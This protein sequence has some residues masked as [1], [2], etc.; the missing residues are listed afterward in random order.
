VA[1]VGLTKARR[2]LVVEDSPDIRE[3]WVLWFTLAGFTVTVAA[4]GR[5]ALEQVRRERPDVVLMDLSMPVM[6]GIEASGGF[7]A[8]RPQLICRFL[9]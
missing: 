3:L 2:I 6:D 5:E 9:R 4:N 1:R 7:A 8:T